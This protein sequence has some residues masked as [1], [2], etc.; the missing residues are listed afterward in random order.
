[1]AERTTLIGYYNFLAVLH[2]RNFRNVKKQELKTQHAVIHTS[3]LI[4]TSLGIWAGLDSNVIASPPIP[5]FCSL[6][7]WMGIVTVVMFLSQVGDNDVSIFL[8]NVN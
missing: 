7:S 2:F 8:S 1:M 6:H 3:I 5:K 4:L